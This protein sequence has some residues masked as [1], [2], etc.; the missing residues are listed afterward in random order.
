MGDS[1]AIVFG[2]RVKE[3]VENRGGRSRR[4]PPL[5]T[6][7]QA[8]KMEEVVVVGVRAA[9]SL[10]PHAQQ[11][12]PICE[13]GVLFAQHAAKLCVVVPRRPVRWQQVGSACAAGEASRGGYERGQPVALLAWCT[14]LS[15][16]QRSSRD[17]T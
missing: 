15:R 14:H 6:L 3:E 10:A 13:R 2:R 11:F 7:A 8:V 12:V 17:A 9:A 16:V 5:R 1:K 4:A